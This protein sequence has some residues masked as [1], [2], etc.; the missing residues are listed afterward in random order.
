MNFP[1]QQQ[2]TVLFIAL[3]MLLVITL[4]GISSMREVMLESRI[5]GNLIEQK[6]LSGSAE[7]ALRE[8]E[9]RITNDKSVTDCAESSTSPCYDGEATD[10]NYTFADATAYSG[11]DGDTELDRQARWYIRLIGGPYTAG[12]TGAS[13]NGAS[14]ALAGTDEASSGSSFYYEVNAQSYKEGEDSDTCLSTSL[15]LTSTVTLFI[16]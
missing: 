6:K 13:A 5:T 4:L 12:S 9:R 11:L 14:N 15:C 1:G 10:E 2:G 8:A 16:Q 7:S 3:V